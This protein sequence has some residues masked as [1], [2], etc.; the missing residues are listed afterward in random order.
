MENLV[1]RLGYTQRPL[2]NPRGSILHSFSLLCESPAFSGFA[3]NHS[4]GIASTSALVY[5]AAT[6]A[7]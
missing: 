4:I 1:V 3:Q 6:R 5:E 2:W 7:A